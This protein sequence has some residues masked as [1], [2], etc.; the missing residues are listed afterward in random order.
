VRRAELIATHPL[1][2]ASFA[3]AAGDCDA[4]RAVVVAARKALLPMDCERARADGARRPEPLPPPARRAGDQLAAQTPGRTL[5]IC[6]VQLVIVA[7]MNDPCGRRDR[8]LPCGRQLARK[9]G[10]A[11]LKPSPQ[12]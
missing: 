1:T 8:P 5:A 6:D 7:N 4:A 2:P 10:L 3:V 12:S 11:G 9:P